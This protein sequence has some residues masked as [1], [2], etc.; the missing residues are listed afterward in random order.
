MEDTNQT[1]SQKVSP[2]IEVASRLEVVS[3]PT[4]RRRWSA[5][6]KAR[7]VSESYEPGVSV[8]AVARRHDVRANQLF[9]WC[10]RAREGKLVVP[11]EVVGNFVPAM[12]EAPSMVSSGCACSRIEI[13]ADGVVVRLPGDAPA[14]RIGEIV[15]EISGA[16]RPS[17]GKMGR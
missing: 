13:E 7:I 17:S 12:V 3:G 4:G 11:A 14:G 8:S 1:P 10:R 9:A 6:M 16:L 5:E 15:G 2:L